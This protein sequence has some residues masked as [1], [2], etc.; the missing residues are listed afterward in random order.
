M[1]FLNSLYEENKKILFERVKSFL[2][3][4]H[5]N[6]IKGFNVSEGFLIFNIGNGQ[7]IHVNPWLKIIKLVD[8]QSIGDQYY[9]APRDIAT[10]NYF[11]VQAEM[12]VES[13]L[14]KTSAGKFFEDLLYPRSTKDLFFKSE[15]FTCK[16]YLTFAITQTCPNHKG[17]Y[18]FRVPKSDHFLCI[19][20]IKVYWVDD[21]TY[22]IENVVDGITRVYAEPLH[23]QQILK[24]IKLLL[25]HPK[26]LENLAKV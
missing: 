16:S 25:S 6:H 20:K 19:S 26:Y 12:K 15:L 17:E 8:E 4:E 11:I 18:K 7:T 3:A 1:D 9:S 23:S 21:G 24:S 2:K 14:R 5:H 13:Y 10:L 22:T